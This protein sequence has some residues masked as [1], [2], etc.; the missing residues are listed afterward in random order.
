MKCSGACRPTNH[1]SRPRSVRA[2]PRH[3]ALSVGIIA[4]GRGYGYQWW[5]LERGIFA[6][7][8]HYEQLIY[9][10]PEADMVVVFT[11]SI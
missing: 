4:V 7:Q 10:V 2:Q 3:H 11:G 8:G 5:T 9:V 6:A 1:W